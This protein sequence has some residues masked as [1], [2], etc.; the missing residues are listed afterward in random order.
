M[1]E[2]FFVAV[3]GRANGDVEAVTHFLKHTRRIVDGL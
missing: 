2:A 1:E 3:R